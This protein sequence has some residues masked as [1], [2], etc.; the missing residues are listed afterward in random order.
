MEAATVHVDHDPTQQHFVVDADGHRAE[1]VYRRDSAGMTITHT[2]VPEAIAGRGI[3]AALVEA[4]LEFARA[5]GLKVVPACS[6]AQAYMRRH[7]Q[8]QDLLA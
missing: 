8:F 5:S 3:A 4:A 7:P 1:L 2:L 6:Y